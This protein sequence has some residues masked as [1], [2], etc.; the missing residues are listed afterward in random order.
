MESLPEEM[1]ISWLKPNM[2]TETETSPMIQNKAEPRHADAREAKGWSRECLLVGLVMSFCFVGLSHDFSLTA[3]EKLSIETG[4]RFDRQEELEKN[5]N[6][7]PWHRKVGFLG[8]AL[9]GVYCLATSSRSVRFRPSLVMMLFGCY[10]VLMFGSFFWSVERGETA[11][12]L[13]RI[14]VYLFA[15]AALAKKFRPRELFFILLVMTLASVLT[16]SS[17]EVLAGNFK[18][19]VSDFRLHGTLHSNVLA[20]QA[21]VALLVA[22][23]FLGKA[24]YKLPWRMI[25]LSMLTVIILTK[26]RGA[27]ASGLFGMLAIFVVDRPL[28]STVMWASLLVSVVSFFG[29]LVVLGGSQLQQELQSTASLGRSEG[30][31]TL[32]GRLPLWKELW[33]ES[34]GHRLLGHGYGAF[35]TTDRVRQ[36]SKTLKWFPGH[37][38][39]VYVHTMLDLG[40]VGVLVVL[41]LVT[42][43]LL[44]AASLAK[45]HGQNAYKFVFGLLAAGVLDGIVE[46]SFIYPRGLGFI[47]AATL[48]SLIAVHPET[49][50]VASLSVAA[51][52]KDSRLLTY[53]Q[54]TLPTG[55]A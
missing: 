19:W 3:V 47:V 45:N 1:P 29:L 37:A 33:F 2:P 6:T 25:V 23:T 52:R 49:M 28:R 14:A 40:F 50:S 8:V 44:R 26:T 55:L 20:S 41:G 12:E 46:V 7:A 16:A 31:T 18:P 51:S 17:A 54:R 43:S 24:T 35:F 4:S 32:T 9:V 5:V 30:V 36:L 48:F 42:A 13:I 34:T 27:L 10:I 39:S 22:F 38:H 11:K 15:T 21:M 53:G